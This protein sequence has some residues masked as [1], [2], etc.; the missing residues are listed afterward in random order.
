MSLIRRPGRLGPTNRGLNASNQTGT[1]SRIDDPVLTPIYQRERQATDVTLRPA[2]PRTARDKLYE[3]FQDGGYH[4]AHELANFAGI[5]P[6]EWYHAMAKL[7]EFGCTFTRDGNR[8][9]M[10][11]GRRTVTTKNPGQ[12]LQV[13]L[14]GIDATKP[15]FRSSMH[16]RQPATSPSDGERIV[17]PGYDTQ[18]D[19]LLDGDE[20]SG[21]Q[22]D[23]SSTTDSRPPPKDDDALRLTADPNCLLS[24]RATVTATRSILAKKSSGKT[25]LAM[26]VA[27]ELLRLTEETGTPF[28]FIVL[29]PT[30]VWH[31]LCATPDGRPS[32]HQILILGGPQGDWDITPADGATVAELAVE[33]WPLP[34]ILDISDMLPED[35]HQ[36]AAD[37]GAKFYTLNKK[38]VHLFIDEADEF[39]PQSIGSG[40][41]VQRRCLGVFDRIIRRGRVK[42]I[43][44]TVIT[45]RPA[46]INK[47]TLS[48]VDGHFIL[49]LDAPHDLEAVETW[50]KSSISASERNL[51]L[52]ALPTLERGE[53][54]FVQSHL[55][56]GALIKFKT[57]EKT[58]FDSSRTPT[59]DDPDPIPPTLS[60]ISSFEWERAGRM[61]GRQKEIDEKNKAEEAARGDL[62]LM[63]GAEP[64]PQSEGEVEDGDADGQA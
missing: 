35:Q 39:I 13:L 3:I 42:G 56:S 28:P 16:A 25:Y 34:I 55:K 51:C 47:N 7:L 1:G 37:F 5:A 33:L 45:Q 10:N 46:V 61:L 30:G 38:P 64:Q 62:D 11:V 41:K 40:D 58:T 15:D 63:P 14:A 24:A 2:G 52:H 60:K 12:D 49:H 27:E 20:G 29:D 32:L 9:L 4:S 26:V 8:L 19:D 36:F 43:G 50:L 57:R 6:G 18:V 21:F 17:D 44:S 22:G 48:Q 31:G 23:A 59:V 53:V 54:F